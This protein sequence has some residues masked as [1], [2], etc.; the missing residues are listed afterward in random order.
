MLPAI[1]A[2]LAKPVAA[3][4][5]RA[6]DANV[7]LPPL[8]IAKG[9][10]SHAACKERAALAEKIYQEENAR[11]LPTW[12]QGRWHLADRYRQIW[13]YAAEATDGKRSDLERRRSLHALIEL[14]GW[15]AV[16][17]GELP[18]PIPP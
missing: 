12:Q 4:V 5:R 11:D 6:D 1:P 17:T 18:G 13:T 8:G 7:A 9:L 15:R 3:M 2:D 10:A 14:V 16:L